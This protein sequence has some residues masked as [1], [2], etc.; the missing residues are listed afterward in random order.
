MV[1]TDEPLAKEIIKENSNLKILDEKLTEDS[2]AFAINPSK[3]DLQNEINEVLNKMKH[4]GKITR[5]RRKMD[6]K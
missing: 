6:G 1:L 5:I 3:Q 4:N 2:Y